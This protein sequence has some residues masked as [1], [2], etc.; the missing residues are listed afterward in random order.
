VK[1]QT[2]IRNKIK[3]LTKERKAL[4]YNEE[5][6]KVQ[7]EYRDKLDAYYKKIRPEKDKIDEEIETL[8]KELSKRKDDRLPIISK[9]LEDWLQGYTRGATFG[10]QGLKIKE[11]LDDKERFVLV[12]NPGHTYWARRGEFHYGSSSYWIT[13]TF[14]QKQWLGNTTKIMGTE[15]EGR[16]TKEVKKKLLEVL[17]EYKKVNKIT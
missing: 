4:L 3:E 13:D 12:Y 5:L 15:V 17:E 2:E 8:R 9:R 16:L 6:G 1:T 10:P 14:I 7:K 11:I